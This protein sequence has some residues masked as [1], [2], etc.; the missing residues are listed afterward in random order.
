MGEVLTLAILNEKILKLEG[1]IGSALSLGLQLSDKVETDKDDI[2][3]LSERIDTI[4][5]DADEIKGDVCYLDTK[6]SDIESDCDCRL[7]DVEVSVETAR[8]YIDDLSDR[9]DHLEDKIDNLEA[10]VYSMTVNLTEQIRA[11]RQCAAAKQD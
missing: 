6:V 1:G 11:V 3:K 10:S 4:E 7:N 8:E 5:Y 9:I 2:L